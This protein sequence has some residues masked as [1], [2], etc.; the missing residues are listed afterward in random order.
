VAKLTNCKHNKF[1]NNKKEKLQMIKQKI[2]QTTFTIGAMLVGNVVF[3]QTTIN[4]ASNSVKIGA[5]QFEYSIG[6]MTLISTER[7]SDLIVTQGFLQPNANTKTV[8]QA[9]GS[10]SDWISQIKVYPNPTDNLLFFELNETGINEYA[11]QI[12]DAAG[13][14]IATQKHTTVLGFNQIK[15]D[16]SSL[17]A[18][19]YFLVITKSD[20]TKTSFKIQKTSK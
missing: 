14:I 3:G 16:V 20:D 12:C 9:D 18:G 1:F 4:A 2:L 11:S 6:E 19:T 5:N 13:K 15:Y 10:L 7:N 17:A 8:S